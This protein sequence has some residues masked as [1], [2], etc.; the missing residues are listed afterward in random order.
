MPK[1]D[2]AG[3]SKRADVVREA[4]TQLRQHARDGYC[5]E[6]DYVKGAGQRSRRVIEPT[7]FVAGVASVMLRSVQH[8]P[9]TGL[10]VFAPERI[11]V[12][13]R[14]KTRRTRPSDAFLAAELRDPDTDTDRAGP[15]PGPRVGEYI[16][17]V[18]EVLVDLTVDADEIREVDAARARLSLSLAE[19][20]AAHAIVFG[21]ILHAFACDLHLD[22]SEEEQLE[23][24]LRGLDDLGWAPQ[25]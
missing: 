17:I 18:R 25:T 20:R 15:R 13:S 5:S 24:A 11:V 8:S 16:N 14:S 21:E 3:Q 22:S 10:R 12:I 6:I 7:H 9:E 19:V 23:R 2:S 4:V 1:K